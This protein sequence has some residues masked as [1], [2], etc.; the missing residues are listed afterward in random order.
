MRTW[1]STGP[2]PRLIPAYRPRPPVRYAV[3]TVVTAL[4]GAAAALLGGAYLVA[5]EG[6]RGAP[7]KFDFSE[8]IEL[9]AW[10]MLGTGLLLVPLAL[11]ALRGYEAARFTTALLA[12]FL[13][14]WSASLALAFPPLLLLTVWWAAVVLVLFHASSREFCQESAAYRSAGRNGPSAA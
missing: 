1:G 5:N 8:V 4:S 12:G 3:V 14:C 7:P 10:A 2:G 6:P 11:A 13:A 9:A